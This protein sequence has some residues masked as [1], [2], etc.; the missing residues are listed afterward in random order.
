MVHIAK[1]DE[2][3]GLGMYKCNIAG[4]NKIRAANW[5]IIQQQFVQLPAEWCQHACAKVTFG[6]CR[7]EAEVY[8]DQLSRS[9]GNAAVTGDRCGVVSDPRIFEQQKKVDIKSCM[10]SKID[11]V[12]RTDNRR[13]Q[14]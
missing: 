14:R 12:R 1:L 13:Y 2:R 6:V 7:S 11:H 8:E 9:S 10:G 3:Y 5:G 4:E